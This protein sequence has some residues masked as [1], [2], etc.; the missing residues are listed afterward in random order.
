M[1]SFALFDALGQDTARLEAKKGYKNIKLGEKITTISEYDWPIAKPKSEGDR[2]QWLRYAH[3][4]ARRLGNVKLRMVVVKSFD[5]RIMEIVLRFKPQD[6]SEV[7][8]TLS[9]AY[10]NS[11]DN[12][13]ESKSVKLTINDNRAAITYKPLYKEYK[14]YKSKLNI[15]DL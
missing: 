12:T 2:V 1:L 3:L 4:P 15:T 9:S 10:G 5:D 6:Y 11:K 13:W 8:S 7:L 14:K